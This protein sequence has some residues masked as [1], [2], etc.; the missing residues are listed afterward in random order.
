MN[1][2][3]TKSSGRERQSLWNYVMTVIVS[4][5]LGAAMTWLFMSQHSTP[6]F[7]RFHRPH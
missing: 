7:A 3:K 5:V 2:R 6:K 1:E 4:A